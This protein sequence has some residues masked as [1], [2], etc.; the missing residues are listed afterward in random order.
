MFGMCVCMYVG[1]AGNPIVK[2]TCLQCPYGQP[3]K[4]KKKK[5]E[6]AGSTGHAVSRVRREG[7]KNIAVLCRF[8]QA[9]CEIR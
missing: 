3:K 7:G 1:H 8:F 6:F 5:R 2:R 9:S 4:K